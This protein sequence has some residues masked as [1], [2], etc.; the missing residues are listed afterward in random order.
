MGPGQRVVTCGGGTD[1]LA[2]LI[3]SAIDPAQCKLHCAVYNGEHYPI[4]VLSNDPHEWELWS[5][6]RGINND[7]NRHFIFSLAQDRHDPTL[8]LFGG[9]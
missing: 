9:V 1:P 6:W 2:S 3:G 4:D 8:W 5:R 7:F